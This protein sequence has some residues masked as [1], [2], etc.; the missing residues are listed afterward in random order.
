MKSKVWVT[1]GDQTWL[2]KNKPELLTCVDHTDNLPTIHININ[3]TFQIIDG[4]GFALTGGSAHLISGL[5][6]NIRKRLLNELFSTRG[7]GI[8]IS[9]LRLSIGASDLSTS[10]YSYLDTPVSQTNSSFTGFNLYAGDREVVP[11]LKEI[12]TINP[13]I[14]IMSSPWSAPAWMKDNNSLIDGRL[15]PE[16]YGLYAQYLVKYLQAMQNEGIGI[17]TITP[18]N[19]PLNWKNEPSMLMSDDEQVDF[20]GNYLGPAIRD[21]EL[22]TK[23][24]CWDQN[25]DNPQYPLSILKDPEA[26]KFIHGS[27]WHLYMGEP[28]AMS[29]VHDAYP[30]KDIYFTEQWLGI[31]DKFPGTLKW[32]ADRVLIGSTRNWAKTVLEWNLAADTNCNPH[33]PAGCAECVGALTIGEAITRNVNY[34]V[35]AHASKFI[36]AGSVR[37]ASNILPGL[38]NVAFRTPD[39]RTALIVLN[40]TEEHQ[41]CAIKQSDGKRGHI[42]RLDLPAGGLAT[43]VW[44]SCA[45][46]KQKSCPTSGIRVAYN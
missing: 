28:E 7:K 14:K 8:G 30:D 33:T 29:V 25:C 3:Q 13:D 5:K 11:L 37:I 9:Y 4:F 21:A 10:T 31:N 39:D 15:R 17:D 32:H 19:E 20:I 23:I 44:A 24:I 22:T 41:Q 27:A 26:N 45:K 35:I 43:C 40:N 12:L 2:L 34:Y 1:S 16:C 46:R 42:D 18:Q 36:P 38:P 6:S